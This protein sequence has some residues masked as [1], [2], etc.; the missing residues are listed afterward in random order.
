MEN[1]FELILLLLVLAAGITA[2]AKKLNIAYPIVLVVAGT[3]IGLAPI[4]GLE[5]LKRFVAEEEVFRFAVISIF[6]PALLGEAT[7]KLPFSH[8]RENKKPILILALVGTF[9]SY[10]VAG[11]LFMGWIG[12][13]AAV[14]FTFAALIAATDPVSVLSIFKSM[15]VNPRLMTIMEGESLVND[16]LAVVLFNISS[17]SLLAYLD[18]GAAGIGLA[19]LELLK[20]VVGGLA[21]GGILSY[22]FS[23]LTRFFDDYPLEIIFSIILFYGSF[24]VAELF[25]V[26]GVIAV[27]TAG[28]IFGNYGARI[29][30][31]PTTKLNIRTFWDVLAL[32][33][34]SLVFFMVGLEVTAVEIGDKWGSITLAILI[35]L[36][37]RSVAVYFSLLPVRDLPRT[38]KHI[39]NWGGLKGSLSIA[40]ALSLPTDFP[41]RDD[42]LLLAYSVVLFSLIV[43]GL[44]IKPLVRWLGVKQESNR[45][46]EYE[47]KLALVQRSL[48]AQEELNRLR[49]KAT[50]SPVLHEK[51]VQTYEEMKEEA[52]ERLE[53][54]Y[55]ENP[56]LQR[57]QMADAVQL[58]LY[59]EHRAVD[60]METE[61]TISHRMADQHRKE[62]VNRLVGNEEK[63]E[64]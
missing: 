45:L 19:G 55:E 20:V 61:H 4:K 48:S 54:L 29:G 7:L 21:V 8:L 50:L 38:W 13:S 37:A 15:R 2:I 44:T 22:V 57:E 24:L 46:S 26:S 27:V 30:M 47:N 25:H 11:F 52:L 60:E 28:L 10:M 64:T 3:L 59:A 36:I 56:E 62:I 31:N 9:L 17:L 5:E 6:L 14:A 23:Q 63:Q 41:G 42:V 40:L 43:Q 51:L 12:F 49:E 33:A 34:N 18:A 53:K 1:T 35:V 32:L 16:G 58:A 39:F